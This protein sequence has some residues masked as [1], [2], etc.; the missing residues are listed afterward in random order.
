MTKLT[1]PDN[2]PY[3]GPNDYGDPADGPLALG[4]LAEATQAALNARVSDTGDTMTGPLEVQPMLYL[5]K[6]G[7]SRVIL[8]SD[9]ATGRMALRV[10]TQD[11]TALAPVTAAPA[12]A[13]A[14]LVT[15]SQL[16]DVARM[17]PAGSVEVGTTNGRMRVAAVSMGDIAPG[18]IAQFD[19]AVVAGTHLL[20]TVQHPSTYLICTCNLVSNTQAQ[21]FVRNSAATT[22]MHA[23][24]VHILQINPPGGQGHRASAEETI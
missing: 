9:G 15:L 16:D 3:P 5:H 19:F 7:S 4:A 14:E 21:V 18:A 13:G 10:L 22:T 1:S 24:T 8:E 23:V 6:P 17:D 2:L 11:Y 20:A 12:M